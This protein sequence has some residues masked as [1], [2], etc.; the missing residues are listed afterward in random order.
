MSY[1]DAHEQ[2]LTAAWTPARG[3]EITDSDLPDVWTQAL[4]R[5]GHDLHV[6]QYNGEIQRIDW[7]AKYDGID[8][9][10]F[11]LSDVSVAG[12]GRQGLGMSGSG[13][14]IDDDVETVLTTIADLVQDQ[15]ARAH[16]AWPWSDDGGF[17]APRLVAHVA[18]WCKGDTLV[19][20]GSL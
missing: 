20:I 10:V 15:V 5:L 14:R 13:V 3:V 8:G 17:L 19:P 4:N 2:V 6:R 16:V 7:V 9:W 11:L 12:R 18:T 1:L